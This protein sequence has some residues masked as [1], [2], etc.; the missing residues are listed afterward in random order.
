MMEPPEFSA[1]LL[2]RLLLTN[3]QDI[4]RIFN[5]LGEIPK[6]R[7]RQAKETIIMWNLREDRTLEKVEN[8]CRKHNVEDAGE[9]HGE[10]LGKG[11]LRGRGVPN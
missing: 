9:G 6:T 3:E 2:G 1:I 4:Q 10:A 11:E 8:N 5:V 7:E